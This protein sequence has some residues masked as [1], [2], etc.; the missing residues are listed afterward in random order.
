LEEFIL[1]S[2]SSDQQTRHCSS[3]HQ[4]VLLLITCLLYPS[5]SSPSFAEVCRH[6]S[7]LA[8]RYFDCPSFRFKLC[9]HLWF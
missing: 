4:I 1:S 6:T 9:S 3:S 7:A 5:F 2:I 8:S